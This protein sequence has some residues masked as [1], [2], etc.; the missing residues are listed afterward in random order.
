[1]EVSCIIYFGYLFKINGDRRLK[2]NQELVYLGSLLL[3][4]AKA[5]VDLG[6]RIG[7][8]II[9]FKELEV[10]LRYACV[11]FRLAYYL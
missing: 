11:A 6:R 10:V 1:M 2:K 9:V 3:A 4:D 7:V 8:V 5:Q